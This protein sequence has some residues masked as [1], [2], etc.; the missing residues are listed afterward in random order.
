MS[1]IV[2]GKRSFF[3][4]LQTSPNSASPPASKKI[5]CF[6]STSPVRFS[7]FA[8]SPPSPSLVDK[9]RSV[10]PNMDKKVV[11]RLVNSAKIILGIEIIQL[12]TLI[13]C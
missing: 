10:F 5:R 2:C 9:L 11:D 3:E 12:H 4:D 13:R 1:A 8:T 7:S 6:T